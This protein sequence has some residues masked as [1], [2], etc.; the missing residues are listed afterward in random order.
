MLQ[1]REQIFIVD[2]FF[3]QTVPFENIYWNQVHSRAKLINHSDSEPSQIVTLLRLHVDFSLLVQTNNIVLK[4]S[5]CL[6][7]P[8]R[9]FCAVGCRRPPQPLLL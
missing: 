3:N 2:F 1:G 5:A 8:L 7:H 9:V 4:G 6:Q